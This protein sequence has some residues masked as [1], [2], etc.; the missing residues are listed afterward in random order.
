MFCISF[1]CSNL[2][3]I[4]IKTFSGFTAVCAFRV[5]RAS[6]AKELGKYNITANAILPGFI[7]TD[8]IKTVPQNLLDQWKEDHPLKRFGEPSEVAN[9]VEFLFPRLGARNIKLYH[10]G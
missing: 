7:N 3:L 4:H 10:L 1:S 2:Y 6:F 8:I 9:V 5:R